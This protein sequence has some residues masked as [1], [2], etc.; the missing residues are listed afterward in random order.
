[1]FEQRFNGLGLLPSKTEQYRNFNVALR[2]FNE[3]GSIIL[4]ASHDLADDDLCAREEALRCWRA[5]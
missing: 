5:Y 3:L 2:A 4:G 1:M